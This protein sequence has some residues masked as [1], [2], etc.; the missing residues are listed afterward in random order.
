VE[1]SP[2]IPAIPDAIETDRLILRSPMPGDGHAVNEAILETWDAL[3]RWM[4]WAR[5]RPT[6]AETEQRAR[7]FRANFVSRVDLPMFMFLRE[8]PAVAVGGTGLHRMDWTVPRFEIGYWVRRS[9]EGNGYVSEAVRALTRL[10]FGPL[11]AQRVEI[12]CSHRHERSQRVAER[13]GFVLE[14]R[15]RNQRRETTGEL[16]DTL[17]YALLPSDLATHITLRGP[18]RESSIARS[19]A[20]GRL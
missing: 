2:A 5:E 12:H 7:Q 10:A 18:R 16:R 4:P 15:L 20:L 13:C 6:V 17:V 11:G 14:G 19:R 9:F 3:H 1:H 8:Q